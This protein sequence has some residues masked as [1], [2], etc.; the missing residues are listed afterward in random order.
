[1]LQAVGMTQNSVIYFNPQNKKFEYEPTYSDIL[2]K[3]RSYELIDNHAKS[4]REFYKTFDDVKFISESIEHIMFIKNN[5][6]VNLVYLENSMIS[7]L[8]YTIK[9]DIKF[10][11]GYYSDGIFTLLGEDNCVYTVQRRVLLPDKWTKSDMTDVVDLTYWEN[12]WYTLLRNGSVCGS[13]G[14]ILYSDAKAID[15]NYSKLMI[16]S[17]VGTVHMIYTKSPYYVIDITGIPPM[18][19]IFLSGYISC[20]IDEN[21]NFWYNYEFTHSMTNSDLKV[22]RLFNNCIPLIPPI[23]TKSA[24]NV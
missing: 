14:K 21:D 13:N 16:L 15:S 1:M 11:K 4:V 6:E 3:T 8:E 5:G 18:K 9:S 24:R 19:S 2:M 22:I 10:I 12:T 7:R 20:A 23:E 17:E